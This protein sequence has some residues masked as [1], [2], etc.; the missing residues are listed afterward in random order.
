MFFFTLLWAS[1]WPVVTV[2]RVLCSFFLCPSLLLWLSIYHLAFV[3]F[4]VLFTLSALLYF[5][6]SLSFHLHL[7]LCFHLCGSWVLTQWFNARTY[8]TEYFK[9]ISKKLTSEQKTVKQQFCF[10]FAIFV[11]WYVFLFLI[12]SVAI[13]RWSGSEFGTWE[14]FNTSPSSSLDVW[15]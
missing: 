5:C 10:S 11:P 7:M 3:N 14:Q 1:L 8:S 12:W 15:S 4:L 2:F 9:C 6:L 13:G